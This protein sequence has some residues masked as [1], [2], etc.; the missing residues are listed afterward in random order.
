MRFVMIFFFFN[1]TY[2]EQQQ[3]LESLI[4]FFI[5]FNIFLISSDLLLRSEFGLLFQYNTTAHK[6]V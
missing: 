4:S 6:G 3:K 5:S 1:E 2:S